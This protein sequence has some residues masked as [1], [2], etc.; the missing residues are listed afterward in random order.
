MQCRVL[1]WVGVF[2]D[3][4]D[5]PSRNLRPFIHIGNGNRHVQFAPQTSVIRGHH[6]DGIHVVPVPIRPG[7]EV[8][9]VGE[10][11]CSP[12]VYSE[13]GPV[14]PGY[15]PG[16]CPALRVRGPVGVNRPG[17]VLTVGEFG[18]TARA[19][20][21]RLVDGGHHNR[22]VQVAVGATVVA[23]HRHLVEVVPVPVGGA[24]VVRRVAEGQ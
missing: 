24:V 14:V 2:L 20:G 4:Y 11:Q 15:R 22:H 19:D 7:L 10:G 17:P 21:G 13:E 9:R 18:P 16:N 23:L 12:V 3:R 6:G 5:F 8:Q 1:G